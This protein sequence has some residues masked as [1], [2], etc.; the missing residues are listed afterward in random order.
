MSRSS[1]LALHSLCMYSQQPILLRRYPKA[2]C[3]ALC[4]FGPLTMQQPMPNLE[5]LSEDQVR[6]VLGQA[7]DMLCGFQG[8]PAAPPPMG[9]TA[10]MTPAPQGPR[11][12]PQPVTVDSSEEDDAWGPW[13]GRRSSRA[14]VDM[15]PPTNL[16]IN[17]H[18][19]GKWGAPPPQ[20]RAAP[21]ALPAPA[22]PSDGSDY[23]GPFAEPVLPARREP[24]HGR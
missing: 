13:P 2:L 20:A 12:G 24:L 15:P 8:V 10:P 21:Q 19:Q 14:P 17:L 6:Q 4:L 23:G 9:P 18:L 22:G 5:G 1:V 16:Q 7:A 11:T 3:Q